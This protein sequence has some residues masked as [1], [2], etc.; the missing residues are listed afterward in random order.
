MAAAA[1]AQD[2]TP[3]FRATS[4]LVLVDVQVIHYKTK[5]ASG[6]LQAKDFHLYEDGVPQQIAFF[7][8]DQ[9]PLSIALL[10]DLTDSVCGVLRRLAAGAQTALTHLNQRTKSG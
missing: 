1:H 7:G 6:V 5:T 10:F 8:R 4:E 9:L 2:A 3:V